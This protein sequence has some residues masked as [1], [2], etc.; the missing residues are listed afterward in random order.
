[1]ISKFKL[2]LLMP[3]VYPVIFFTSLHVIRSNYGLKYALFQIWSRWLLKRSKSKVNIIHPELIPLEN[4]YVF[5]STHDSNFD[6]LILATVLPVETHF[7]LNDKEKLPFINVYSKRMKIQR[8]YPDRHDLD[9]EVIEQN[10]SQSSVCVFLEKFDA[11]LGLQAFFQA[12]IEKHWTLIPVSIKNN[13]GILKNKGYHSAVVEIKTPVYFE[14][15]K[16]NSGAELASLIN[17]RIHLL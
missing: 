6:P 15:Y 3:F 8:I 1:M 11:N 10:L 2:L 14:E 7:I 16:G 5:V 12:A 4:D 9:I 13:E 17:D